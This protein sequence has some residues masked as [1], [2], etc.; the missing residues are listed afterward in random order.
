MQSLTIPSQTCLITRVLRDCEL[1]KELETPATSRPLQTTIPT[2]S[3]TTLAPKK[4][5]TDSIQKTPN[6]H[7]SPLDEFV[8]PHSMSTFQPP[9]KVASPTQFEDV[10]APQSGVSGKTNE[11]LDEAL[12]E[13]V[14]QTN[15]DKLLA[16]ENPADQ[17]KFVFLLS[18]I[19]MAFV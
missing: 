6:P 19:S 18:H 7:L 15:I 5:S 17:G 4:L 13:A 14:A 9:A 10:A 12:F 8:T 3:I 16:D 2:L 11:E 1:A